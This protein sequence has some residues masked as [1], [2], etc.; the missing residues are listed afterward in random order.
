MFI[1]AD[2]TPSSLVPTNAIRAFGVDLV[3]T[4]CVHSAQVGSRY[5]VPTELKRVVQPLFYKHIVPTGLKK[6]PKYLFNLHKVCATAQ[7]V[8]SVF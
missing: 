3:G 2:A 4:I 7:A 6:G 1:A 8:V 5:A